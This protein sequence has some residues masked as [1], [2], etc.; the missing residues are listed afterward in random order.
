MDAFFVS[1]MMIERLFVLKA[2]A[3]DWESQF[4]EDVL[5]MTQLS[6]QQVSTAFM[7]LRICSYY[8]PYL[9]TRRLMGFMSILRS[10]ESPRGLYEDGR[11][12]AQSQL[13]PLKWDECHH[14]Q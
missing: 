7:Q 6:H 2:I 10:S 1:N 13:I 14:H 9:N 5:R 4:T 11:A 8:E 12:T 3:D